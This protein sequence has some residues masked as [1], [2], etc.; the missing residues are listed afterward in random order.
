MA[1][2][3]PLNTSHIAK[4]RNR[5]ERIRQSSP[6]KKISSSPGFNHY[7]H[8][9]LQSVH[10]VIVY[11]WTAAALNLGNRIRYRGRQK[12][13]YFG[14]REA[15]F[16]VNPHEFNGSD[17]K[18]IA[19]AVHVY[20]IDLFEEICDY[21]DRMPIPYSAFISV[22]KP[23]DQWIVEE[24]IKK[25]RR[26]E[27]CEIKIVENRG[28]DIAPMVVDFA[29]SLL[30]FDYICH[31]HTKKS[32][33]AGNERYEW[34]VYLFK[35]LLG[36]QD[37]IK[38]IL[39]V[40]Q[41]DPNMGILYPEAFMDAP[42]WGATWL[43]NKGLARKIH[44][45]LNIR[46]DPDEYLEFPAGS[47][48]FARS[49]ALAPLLRL[50]LTRE[51]FPEESGQHDGT[52]QHTIERSFTLIARSQG[53]K[54]VIIQDGT[55]HKFSRRSMRNIREYLRLPFSE[56]IVKMLPFG[57]VVSID[58]L[59]TLLVSPFTNRDMF[60]L[61]LEDLVAKQYRIER[62]R[63]K[64]T[65][66]EVACRAGKKSGQDV[67]ISEIYSAMAKLYGI[68]PDIVGQLMELEIYAETNLLV[69]R[70]EVI[71]I[72]RQIGKKNKRIVLVSDTCLERDQVEE[73]LR[74]NNINFFDALYISSETGKRK[75]RGD[76]WDYVL[77]TEHVEK[78]KLLH[79]GD[80]EQSDIHSSASRHFLSPV[81]VMQ[82]SKLFR[83]SALGE[84][85]FEI[86]QPWRSWQ[87][88]LLYG[89][90][91]NYF[92][93]DPYPEG[94]FD[95]KPPLSDPSAF[96]YVVIGPGVFNHI[97]SVLRH[98][99]KDDADPLS[100]DL[101][102]RCL[103]EKANQL[104]YDAPETR[105]NPV[106]NSTMPPSGNQDTQ[107]IDYSAIHHQIRSGALRF[108]SDMAALF[109]SSGLLIEFPEDAIRVLHK[110]IA[111]D[112]IPTGDLNQYWV[113]DYELPGSRK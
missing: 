24:K 41:D 61:Y 105:G 84:Q 80:D 92:C 88:N 62:F 55:V 78:E 42:Y 14:D 21:L 40:F 58:I 109:G 51:D 46:F 89:I 52:L 44:E 26:L 64:R 33:R 95:P 2:L 72:A 74:K 77:V 57:Q 43:G 54:H 36:S 32:L 22:T 47:M 107:Y 85:L 113:I 56:K 96:G 83:Q 17:K 53:F 48:F 38:A 59:D 7:F 12:D 101:H 28:R 49:A 20:Y 45:K 27:H 16:L 18:T 98:S 66:S 19:F 63:E 67:K 103:L 1:G 108:I 71:N 73:I 25:L 104:F 106:R 23:E 9:I 50:G 93:T 100:F 6:V 39:S 11:G 82:P 112:E 110:R 8:F 35:M 65:Q 10:I 15:T 5:I 4:I 102:G 79:V 87:A 91:S 3:K 37:R 29:Q 75:D 31:I 76:F 111:E 34:R 90:F 81:H 70:E 30:K 86:I 13:L 94:L 69:P 68:S 60:F 97:N 99:G